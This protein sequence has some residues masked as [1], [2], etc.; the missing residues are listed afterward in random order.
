MLGPL[1]FILWP[2]TWALVPYRRVPYLE[3]RAVTEETCEGVAPSYAPGSPTDFASRLMIETEEVSSLLWEKRYDIRRQR[4]FVPIFSN[5][6]RWNAQ[7]CSEVSAWPE[8]SYIGQIALA[9]CLARI[10][11]FGFAF[12]LICATIMKGSRY[13]SRLVILA[14]S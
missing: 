4:R 7:P 10:M 8:F 3:I 6:R 9:S 14:G 1:I 13:C 5:R 2:R 11:Y 12:Y